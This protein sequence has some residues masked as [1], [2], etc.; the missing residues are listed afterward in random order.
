[1]HVLSEASYSALVP[2]GMDKA[3]N[4]GVMEAY[5][6]KGNVWISNI[7]KP[8][9]ELLSTDDVVIAIKT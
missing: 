8:T 3:L 6:V 7:H 1:M 2:L 4:P 9:S 5:M